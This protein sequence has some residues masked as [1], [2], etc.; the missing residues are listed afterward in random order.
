MSIRK[1]VLREEELLTESG[2]RLDRPVTRAWAAA[3]VANP[4]VG[5]DTADLQ[6]AV[7]EVAP[8]IAQDL[9]AALVSRMGSVEAV[10]AYGKGAVVG[11]SGE[12]E[13]AAA[14]IHTPYFGNL[15]REFLQA[16]SIICFA[17]DRGDA[18]TELSLPMWHKTHA[19]TRTHYQT[20]RVHLGDAPRA[21][22]IVVVL[23]VST[24]GRPRPR[25]GDR[26]TDP[27]VT[28]RVLEEATQ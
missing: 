18:G 8:G 27:A 14:L 1:I 12:L 7:R 13:H 6:S 22:E 15:V 23:G 11:S 26:T 28:S 9:T 24:G 20:I 5:A 10:E 3:V 19:S 17:D 21:D 2:R 25:I 4:W 16:E